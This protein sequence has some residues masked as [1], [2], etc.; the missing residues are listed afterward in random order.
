[1]RG[2]VR[3]LLQAFEPTFD[4]K[5]VVLALPPR[6]VADSISFEPPLSPE[7]SK[8]LK[9]K[10]TW[11]AAHAKFVAVFDQPFWREQGLSG[12]GLSQKGPLLEIHDA[13]PK[14]G[15]PYALFGFVGIPATD[16]TGQEQLIVQLALEQINRMFGNVKACPPVSTHYKDWAVDPLTATQADRDAAAVVHH[17]PSNFNNQWDDRIIFAG[18]ETAVGDNQSNGY[19]EGALESAERALKSMVM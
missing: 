5:Q 14:S 4:A 17:A 12:D 11:M 6:V 9:A 8:Q 15:G 7:V 3:R 19:L 18:T 16:R 10:A 13:S 2:A 1:M